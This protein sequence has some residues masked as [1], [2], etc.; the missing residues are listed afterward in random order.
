ML[1]QILF[2]VLAAAVAAAAGDFVQFRLNNDVDSA[3]LRFNQSYFI[4]STLGAPE[5]RHDTTSAGKAVAS[6]NHELMS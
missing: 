1:R 4:P 3:L 5:A 2:S 6:E